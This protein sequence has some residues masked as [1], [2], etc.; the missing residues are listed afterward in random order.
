MKRDIFLAT[1]SD[2]A[3]DVINKYG[4]GM[5]LNEFCISSSLD[6]GTRQ[7]TVAA[8]KKEMEQC[9]VDSPSKA[10]VHGPFTEICPQS[11]DHLAVEM[12]LLRLNQA[13]EG[14]RALGLDRL[15]VHSGFIP[16]IY[17]NEW[18]VQQSV[19]FWKEFMADKPADFHIYIENV[20]DEEPGPLLQIVEEIDDPRVMLCLD[21]GHANVVT[22]PDYTVEDWIKIWGSHIGH[23]HFHNNDGVTDLHDPLD[24]GTLNIENVL[25]TIDRY[26][27]QS[28][29]I[30]VESRECDESIRWLMEK[31]V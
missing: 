16:L 31:A 19:K 27:D 10:L 4:C 23:F 14:T 7:E 22:L 29:T 5:E 9:G 17:F 1:F 28:A 12:G 8:M 3:T 26:C 20:L 25:S 15:V 13:Y 6:D 11:I 30:T 2:K 18:H 24:R 21:I